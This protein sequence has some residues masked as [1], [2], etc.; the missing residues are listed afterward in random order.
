MI[1]ERLML[2]EWLGLC[3]GIGKKEVLNSNCSWSLYE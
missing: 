2:I 1:A 3:L